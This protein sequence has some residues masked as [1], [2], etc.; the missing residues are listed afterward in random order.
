MTTRYRVRL[1]TSHLDQL[2]ANIAILNIEYSGLEFNQ[3]QQN[4]ANLDG[5]EIIDKKARRQTVTVTFELHIYDTAKRNAACQTINAWAEKGGELRTSDRSGQFLR[6]TCE[7]YAAINARDWTQPLTLVFATT[8]SPYW[9]SDTIKSKTLS[10]K[11]VSSTFTL[12]GN[13]SESMVSATITSK[14][15]TVKSI[16]LTAANTTIE[17]TGLS[18]AKNEYVDIAYTNYRYLR[19]RHYSTAGKNKGSILARLKA[20]SSDNLAI[21]CGATSAIG[22]TADNTVSAVFKARGKWL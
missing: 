20:T 22:V 16:K 13:T 14:T 18:V 12:D 15:G 11:N 10:G 7:Q 17:L 4:T 5:N 2:N 3:T 19:I 1:G 8:G 9:Q 6:V 21:A